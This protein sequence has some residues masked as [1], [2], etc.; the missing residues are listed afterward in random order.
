M[1]SPFDSEPWTRGAARVVAKASAPFVMHPPAVGTLE[2]LAML[3]VSEI[4]PI[5]PTKRSAELAGDAA[6]N[7]PVR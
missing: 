1:R 7:A 6:P 2:T 4:E 3:D 5:P